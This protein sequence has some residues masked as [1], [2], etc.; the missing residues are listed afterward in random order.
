MLDSIDDILIDKVT[1]FKNNVINGKLAMFV[2]N[3]L[4]I[5]DCVQ[6]V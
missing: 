1:E 5:W 2:L 4:D 6:S 3:E